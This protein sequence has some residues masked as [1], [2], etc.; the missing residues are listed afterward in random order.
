M[1]DYELDVLIVGGG[2]IGSLLNLALDKTGLKSALVDDCDFRLEPQHAAFD[3]RSLALAPASVRIL[4]MLGIWAEV[5]ADASA[6]EQIHVSQK[7]VFGQTRLYAEADPLGY[8]LEIPYLSHAIAKKLNTDNLFMPAKLIAFDPQQNIATI[9][10]KQQQKLIRAKI[11]IGADGTNSYLRSLCNLPTQ[12]KSFA[13]D[14]I[15]A[16][17]ELSR[18][19]ANCAY[20][21]FTKDGPLA[22]L[23]L[24]NNRMALV[25]SQP[26]VNA[27]KLCN[28][29]E[30]EFLRELQKTFGYRVG[31]ILHVGKRNIYSLTHLTM[32]KVVTGSVVFIGNAANTLH[33][34]AGQGFNLG[35]R[36][37][38]ML[39]Q[40][41]KNDGLTAQM[42][43]KY[44]E[45]RFADQRI[46]RCFTNSLI[47]SYLSSFPGMPHIR[48]LCLFTLDNLPIA[49]KKIINIA[50]G[51]AGVVSDLACGIF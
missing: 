5:Q 41:I 29:S 8:V 6:I 40:C 17:I 20:E 4:Q 19:H 32:P 12:T 22:L 47:S 42:L 37:V 7:G 26:A 10:H 14:A 28:V 51:F 13:T 46:I 27:K 2:L 9:Q 34:V 25:W 11:V 38:A 50:S 36:D 1:V 30:T 3:S 23:P 44:Q 43:Q 18:P 16:N 31:R 45:L 15:V 48:G 33:P 49:K 21:R 39:V 24:T 35:L